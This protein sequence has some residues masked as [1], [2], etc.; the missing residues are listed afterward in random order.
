[1]REPTKCTSLASFLRHK[2]CFGIATN[3]RREWDLGGPV[4]YYSLAD[5][6]GVFLD[7]LRERLFRRERV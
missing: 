2:T 4:V 7:I 6:L 5:E 1:M 3:L